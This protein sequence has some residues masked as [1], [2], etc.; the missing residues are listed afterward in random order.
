MRCSKILEAALLINASLF[1][2]AYFGGNFLVSI[3]PTETFFPLDSLAERV[4]SVEPLYLP[5]APPTG[6]TGVD[7][8]FSPPKI[9]GNPNLAF[10]CPPWS[11]CVPSD[12]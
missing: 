2:E 6:G 4:E 5:G 8:F 9:F 3:G 11:N 1:S 12:K 7:V 10:R